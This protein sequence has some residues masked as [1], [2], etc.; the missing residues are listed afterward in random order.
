MRLFPIDSGHTRLSTGQ[1]MEAKNENKVI[2][3][4]VAEWSDF[5]L[6]CNDLE[7]RI[8]KVI[9]VQHSRRWSKFF[10]ADTKEL[11]KTSRVDL[12][13]QP[14]HDSATLKL[15]LEEIYSPIPTGQI[16]ANNVEPV[17]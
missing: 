13:R 11:P 9:L 6:I 7:I 12:S 1:E 8:H 16:T 17:L 14:F 4:G 15:I 3:L 10:A 5:T 2:S